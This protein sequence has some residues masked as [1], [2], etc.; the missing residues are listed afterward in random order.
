MMIMIMKMMIRKRQPW[1]SRR[2]RP[3]RMDIKI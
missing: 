2:K 3:N 1:T